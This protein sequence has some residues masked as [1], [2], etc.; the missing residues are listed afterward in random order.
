M[1]RDA[2]TTKAAGEITRRDMKGPDRFQ[3]AATG[4]VE[5]AAAHRKAV[6][7]VLGVL[8]AAAVAALAV[9]YAVRSS[10][11]Q[12]GGRLYAALAAVAG[13]ISAVPL[14]GVDR[15]L[16]R[17]EEERAQAVVDAA[18]RVRTEHP[19]SR[20]AATA[21]L[22]VGDAYLRLR[23]WDKAKA[24]F[25]AYLGAAGAGDSLRFAAHDGVARALEGKGDLA[26]AAD[27]F[28]R[29]GQEA[30][31]RDRAALERARVLARAGRAEE[32]RKI[33]QAF[34]EEHK[35]SPLKTEAAERL[36][37]LGGK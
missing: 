3:V 1:I 37:R 11:D 23:A 21:A 6:L 22:A 2:R 24:A 32:A 9:Q 4:A 16:F 25:E 29:A 10:R 15:P 26:G 27:A 17:S 8:G 34:P 12:A 31:Y 14:P 28:E 19:G 36:G 13:E 7:G 33:L 20:A 18:E 5:W 35:N 30:S